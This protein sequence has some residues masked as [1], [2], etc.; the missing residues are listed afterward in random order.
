MKW[1]CVAVALLA[2]G[3]ALA[4]KR[5]SAF[6]PKAVCERARANAQS[7]EWAAAIRN[8]A[9]A[10]AARWRDLPDRELRDM[11]FGPTITRSHMVWSCGY[12]PACRKPVPMYDWQIDA[13]A[14]PWKARCPHCNEQFPKNDFQKF[15]RSG[16]DEKGVFDPKRADRDLLYNTDHPDPADPLHRFGVDDGEGYVERDKRWR[17]I[18]AYLLYGQWSQKIEPGIKNLAAAYTLTGDPVYAYKAGVLL[19]RVA[20]LWPTFD[21]AAQGLVYERAR[22]GGGIAGYVYYAINSAFNV[23]DLVTAYD[24]VFD[25]IGTGARRNIE[26][27]ILRD[28]LRNPLKV[29]TNYPGTE[30]TLALIRAVLDWPSN[31]EE[32]IRDLD[33]IVRKAVAV[34]GLSGEKGLNSYATIAP[35][36]VAE[37]LDQYSAIDPELLPEILKRNPK[38][39]DTYRFH[40]DT[41]INREY[42]PNS[43]DAGSFAKKAEQYAVPVSRSFLARM[44][45]ATRDPLYAQI[46][47]CC[48][49]NMTSLP[50]KP[51]CP[52]GC[53]MPPAA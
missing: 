2:A 17:F 34:D 50:S 36:E 9:I 7:H 47:R 1:P 48:P 27:R 14:R 52:P 10:D 29:R 28:V 18:G 11:M 23:M 42:Y 20:D 44:W 31:R 33:D 45:K 3:T 32:L 19:D 4:E 24:K 22:Y 53:G 41:W 15:Y 13:W 51:R 26:E 49:P 16:L 21:Y 12:C 30:R 39:R 46:A 43:G 6:F 35:R 5:A 38:L 37:I 40:A 8:K 25:G